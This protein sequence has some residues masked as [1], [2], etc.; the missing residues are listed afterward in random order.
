MILCGHSVA[1]AQSGE[2]AMS[3][4]AL[5]YDRA[6]DLI[7]QEKWS[8]ARDIL[9]RLWKDVR[10]HDIAASLAQVEFNLSNFTVAA[11]YMTFALAHFPPGAKSEIRKRYLQGFDE[12][13]E[14][15]GTVSV[16]VSHDGAEVTLDGRGIGR[17]PLAN[18]I[19]VTPGTH[20]VE[21]RLGGA[22]AK[23]TVHVPVKQTKRVDLELVGN[24]FEPQSPP[25][26]AKAE[27]VRSTSAPP[28]STAHERDPVPLVVAGSAGAAALVGGIAFLLVA[29]SKDDERARRVA[30]LQGSNSCAKPI[31]DPNL[32][33]PCETISDLSSEEK[34]FNVLAYTSFGVAAVAAGALTYLLWPRGNDAQRSTVAV[35]PMP[36]SSGFGVQAGWT[37]DF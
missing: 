7:D 27:P 21:A 22:L 31:R 37:T 20:V 25:S 12:I 11:E 5:E 24:T 17:S 2:T 35:A 8:E 13:R 16:F 26:A 1:R 32:L 6:Q 36:S 3:A 10:T 15:I 33:R 29:D 4:Q 23:Q 18:P 9:L 14:H 19:F 34:T 30:R 28:V